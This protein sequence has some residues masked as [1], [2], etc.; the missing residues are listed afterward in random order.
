[1]R[2]RPILLAFVLASSLLLLGVFVPPPLDLEEAP[3]PA[4]PRRFQVS[5]AHAHGPS[6]WRQ[7]GASSVAAP[8]RIQKASFTQATFTPAV[9]MPTGYTPPRPPATTTRNVSVDAPRPEADGLPAAGMH[10]TLEASGALRCG[11]CRVDGDCPAGQGCAVN[12]DTRRQECMAS[13]CEEDT[14]CEPGLACRALTNGATGRV[15]RRC[16]P[17]GRRTEGEACDLGYVSEASACGAGLI[18]L[19][20]RCSMRCEPGTAASCPAGHR[21]E[22]SLE[23]HACHADCQSLGCPDGQ[24][25]KRLNDSD[26]KCLASVK[27]ECPETACGEGER[28]NLRSF[29][30]QGVFW[31]ARR[32]QPALAHACPTGQVC[33]MGSATESTCFQACDP[34]RL[35][36]CAE[37]W[38]CATVSEDLTQWGC[39]PRS[40]F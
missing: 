38:E 6:P 34:R 8:G 22:A 16:M 24:R 14:H 35:D 30:D 25:C 23:G 26:F 39:I 4:S 15:V 33:G 36:A 10:C 7:A 17:E 1:M 2:S 28:C 37:G 20:G 9:S 27:G 5:T 29:R 40:E 12:R 13:D 31:C 21:C 3:P 32:C 19:A 18:C 11:A